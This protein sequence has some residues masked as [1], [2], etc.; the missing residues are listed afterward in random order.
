[1]MQVKCL[2]KGTVI[3]LSLAGARCGGPGLAMAVTNRLRPTAF[4]DAHVFTG[5]VPSSHAGST[6]RVESDLGSKERSPM[7]E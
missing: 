1:M 4:T 3:A 7:E 5:S 6:S 2:S